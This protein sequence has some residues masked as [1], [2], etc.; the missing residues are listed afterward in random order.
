MGKFKIFVVSF[1]GL[2]LSSGLT[3]PARAVQINNKA[4]GDVSDIVKEV[5]HGD[6]EIPK[7]SL[8]FV[9]DVAV[10]DAS[11][12][13]KSYLS[14]QIM[15]FNNDGS[16]S[17]TFK[18]PVIDDQRNFI[19]NA[20]N[21]RNA[22]LQMNP[23]VSKNLIDGERIVMLNSLGNSKSFDINLMSIKRGDGTVSGSVIGSGTEVGSN[24]NTCVY[25][26]G[27]LSVPGYENNIYFLADQTITK[28]EETASSFS[29]PVGDIK[30]KFWEVNKNSSGNLQYE[31]LENLN[32]VQNVPSYPYNH[33][34]QMCVGDFDGDGY[35]NEI[36]LLFNGYIRIDFYVYRLIYSDGK[37]QLKSLGSSSGNNIYN[38]K[39]YIFNIPAFV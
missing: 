1:V 32:F 17:K 7:K 4:L 26:S 29:I 18:L 20:Q 30:L 3:F 33:L 19:I 13:T 35:K 34:V 23:A 14:S 37:L 10:K 21:Q 15:T 38:S 5:T 9:S 6:L 27:F 25:G 11:G 31:S 2:V 16:V 36:A 8:M 39:P 12:N 24:S 22:F 28:T